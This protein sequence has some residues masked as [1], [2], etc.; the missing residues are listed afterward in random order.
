MA[1]GTL[2]VQQALQVSSFEPDVMARFGLHAF[3]T[4]EY[5]IFDREGRYLGTMTPPKG[6]SPMLAH[7]EY[8]YGVQADDLGVPHVV[9]L[10]VLR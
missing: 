9:R 10:R 6:F 7:G 3:A 5:D 2:W 4:P 1:S 8:L